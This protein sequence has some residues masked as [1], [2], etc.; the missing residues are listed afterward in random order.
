[1]GYSYTKC[2]NKRKKKC[3]IVVLKYE[4]LDLVKIAV[5]FAMYKTKTHTNTSREKKFLN[6]LFSPIKKYN[7]IEEDGPSDMYTTFLH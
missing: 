1:M 7:I 3:T 2:F 5:N 4:G 6:L